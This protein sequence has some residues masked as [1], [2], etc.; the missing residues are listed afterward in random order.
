[1]PLGFSELPFKKTKVALAILVAM[2]GNL[3]FAQDIADAST[4]AK[5]VLQ[6]EAESSHITWPLLSGESVNSLARSFYPKNQ[7]M[8]RL[9][10]LKTL[11]LSREIHPHLRSST[12]TNQASLIIIPNIKTLAKHSGKIKSAQQHKHAHIRKNPQQ[13]NLQMSYGLKDA[14]QFALTPKMQADYEN[15]VKRNAQ[16]KLDLEKLNVKLAHLQQVMAALN[17][18]ARRVQSLPAP[19]VIV[20]TAKAPPAVKNI[21]PVMPV[22]TATPSTALFTYLKMA[23]TPLVL[24]LVA[25]AVLVLVRR[26]LSIAQK[27][28]FFALGSLKARFKRKLA[29]AKHLTEMLDAPTNQVDLSLSASEISGNLSDVNLQTIMA[30]ANKEEGELALE[31]ARIYININRV[32]EAVMLLK[33]QVHTAPKASLQHWLYLL[34]IYRDTD[35]K[36]EFWQYAKKMHETFNVITP[37]WDP[38]AP[39]DLVAPT[40]LEEFPHIVEN[41][42]RLWDASAQSAS[43][44]AEAK[45]YIDSLL[46]DNRHHE[47]V[48]F[49]L[50]VL[51]EVMLLSEVLEARAKLVNID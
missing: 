25:C 50:E 15:L 7:K 19:V 41:L 51:Q 34:D 46:T 11:Q 31:Q 26:R 29:N 21:S 47:R 6:Q 3:S 49:S 24:V 20:P 32:R 1:M 35:Q 27:L 23:I 36:E 4:I 13:P 45:T 18:E 37:R 14:D 17:V 33:S 44:Y 22:G 42:T 48:G 16:L 43:Q 39:I 40:S 28:H 9:F 30:L 38:T 8:Q 12:V 5:S 10:V 2:Y